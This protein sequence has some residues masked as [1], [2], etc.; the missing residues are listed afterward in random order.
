MSEYL[1]AEKEAGT[2]EA[3]QESERGIKTAK[4]RSARKSHEAVAKRA[5]PSSS[6]GGSSWKNAR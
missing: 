1:E 5:Q 4:E 3:T 2:Y 6:G